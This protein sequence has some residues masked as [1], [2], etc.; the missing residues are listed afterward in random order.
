M[1]NAIARRRALAGLSACLA[2]GRA[3]STPAGSPPASLM[4]AGPAA[5][6]MDR[7][8]EAIAPALGRALQQP[9]PL[10][11]ENVGGSDGVTGANQFEA[12]AAPDGSLALLVPG[13]AA[14]AW[15]AGDTRVKFDAAR[16][17]PVWAGTR[18]A[19]LASRVALRPGRSV[20]IGVR[21]TMGPELAALLA[22]DLMKVSVRLVPLDPAGPNPMD[23]PDLEAVVVQGPDLHGGPG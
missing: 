19:A 23:R 7:W 17:T 21:G 4:V 20:R 15:L 8:G 9:G 6:R 5:G 14:L 11:R 1:R 13:S 22:L 10:P 12:R 16:W 2:A 18:S 3:W